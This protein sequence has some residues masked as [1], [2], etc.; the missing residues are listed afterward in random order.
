MPINSTVGSGFVDQTYQVSLGVTSIP[1]PIT[2]SSHPRATRLTMAGTI[3]KTQIYLVWRLDSTEISV[4]AHNLLLQLNGCK[5]RQLS[6]LFS[7]KLACSICISCTCRSTVHFEMRVK[8]CIR[9][10]KCARSVLV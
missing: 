2:T 3:C 10:Y 9:F 7:S 4:H 6:W 5:S 8:F 1:N